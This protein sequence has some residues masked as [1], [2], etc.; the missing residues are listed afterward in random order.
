MVAA[1]A[2]SDKTNHQ[3]N[4]PGLS[5]LFNCAGQSRASMTVVVLTVLMMSAKVNALMDVAG[6]A[7]FK[8]VSV[9]YASY[10]SWFASSVFR[11]RPRPRQLGARP[12]S[13]LF[14]GVTGRAAAGG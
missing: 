8:S 1:S 6:Q 11:R 12:Q 9:F 7:S 4:L 3:T 14:G 10:L 5:F 2:S 13:A